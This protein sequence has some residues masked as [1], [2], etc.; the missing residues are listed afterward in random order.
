MRNTDNDWRK[1]AEKEPYWG[2]LSVDRFRGRNLSQADLDVFFETGEQYL[3]YVLDVIRKFHDPEFKIDRALDFGCGVGRLAIP[4]ARAAKGETIGVDVAP[5][6]LRLCAE[7]AQRRK[8]SNLT[9]VEGDD[10][11]SQVKGSFNFINTFLVLQHIPPARGIAI[12]SKLIDKLALGGIASLQ[13]T[14]AK[15]RRFLKHEEGRSPYYRRSDD[16]IVEIGAAPDVR[17]E[18]SITMYDYDLNQLFAVVQRATTY[19]MVVRPTDDDGHIGVQ[20]ILKRTR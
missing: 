20:V 2:V 18:G 14:Y 7:H 9:L 16:G 3:R 11:L 6:M 10:E 4:I 13:L 17:P 15:E 19:P 1:V 12:I 8:I 5:N